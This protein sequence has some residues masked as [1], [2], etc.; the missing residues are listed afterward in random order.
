MDKAAALA[1]R[2]GRR[3]RP[4][5]RPV[6][7]P[8]KASS[9]ATSTPV[10]A[11]GVLD[12]GQLRDGLRCAQRTTSRSSC[13]RSRCRSP[14]RAAV[15][16]D[17]VDPR[18]RARSASAPSCSPTKRRRRSPRTSGAQIVDGQLRKW[19]QSVVLYEQPFR[20]TDQSVGDLITDAIARIGE[21]I[22]VRRFTRYAARG[23]DLSD[24]GGRSCDA[25][26]SAAVPRG[27]TT[28]RR[29]YPLWP[30]P[31]EDQ[32]RGAHGPAL[33]RR[34]SGDD[35]VHRAQVHE[36]AHARRRGGDRR[37]RRQHLPRHRGRGRDGHGP[38]HG[39][40]HGHARHGDERPGAAGR[41]RARAA[42]RRASCRPSP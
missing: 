19:Y 29:T 20:D 31:A 23:G 34:R 4:P 41:P 37:R 16:D 27:R 14:A 15:H 22:R 25:V 38:R 36:V 24:A 35:R 21:N 6:A 2:E 32:R 9:R 40:L 8:A 12:R 7:R 18:G 30:H 28:R 17:R 13:A 10:A 33:V 11:I 1:A 3:P 5:R 42:S 39:R 26:T